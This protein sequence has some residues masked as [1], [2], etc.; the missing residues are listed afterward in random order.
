MN[1]HKAFLFLVCGLTF[2]G[3]AQNVP[4]RSYV[5]HHIEA[6]LLIDGKADE[7]VWKEAAFSEPFIDIEG[8][9][10]PKYKTHVKMLWDDQN[11]Y[12]YAE[13]EEPHIWA[14]LKQ[15]D[16]VIFY[17]NDFE[18][19]IDPDGDTHNYYE[20]EM[21]A[22]NT[23]WDLLLVKPYRESAPV[24][25]SWDIQDLQT[26][27]SINGTLNDPSDTDTSWS[28][29]I[30][31]PWSVLVEAS[32]SNELP[33]DNFWRI[34]FSRVNW[35]F[36]LDE[37][38][39]SRAKDA[40]GKY[41]PEYNWVW[42]PQGIINMHEPEHWGYVYFSSNPVGE[43]EDF[44]IPRDEKIRWK[45]YELYRKQKAY[46]AAHNSWAKDLNDLDAESFQIE[47]KTLK[48]RMDNHEMGWTIFVES[49]FTD[50][51]YSIREDGK[52]SKMN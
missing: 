47:G 13:L 12:F 34:N 35:D 37:N 19:F 44:S 46:Y 5:A 48:P 15:R 42:S 16:T 49:P 29:E 33:V 7:Q 26:A 20:F 9:K 40:S 4:P 22:L 30:A 8:E 3:Y 11:L 2:S 6:P 10:I 52:Y 14:T 32:G 1:I 17:N 43:T 31:M 38:R 27:V 24:L 50:A 45:L 36:E 28:V 25:D 51:V 39:Y 41:L 18:I 21:N 23:V